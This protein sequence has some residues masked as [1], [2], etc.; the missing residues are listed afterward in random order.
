MVTGEPVAVEAGLAGAGP[1]A[2]L[3][4]DRP[5]A[6]DLWRAAETLLRLT[7]DACACGVCGECD[8]F[9]AA[10]DH[11]VYQFGPAIEKGLAT[12]GAFVLLLR[13]AWVPWPGWRARWAAFL[14][15][16]LAYLAAASAADHRPTAVPAIADLCARILLI[17]PAAP[18]AP[19]TI[20][21]ATG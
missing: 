4:S 1:G 19:V 5:G 17:A 7:R 8:K 13:R 20:A 9:R 12:F 11:F 3:A 6:G 14:A 21:G 18:P 16:L 15:L 10:L 2:T